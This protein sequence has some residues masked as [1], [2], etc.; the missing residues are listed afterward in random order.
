MAIQITQKITTEAFYDFIEQ[1]ENQNRHFER[2][3]GRIIEKM[4]SG[5]MA[6]IITA[7]I[8][9][10]LVEAIVETGLGIVTSPEGG[11]IVA[12]Q[13]YMPDVAVML[14]SSQSIEERE[15]E[16]GYNTQ[17]PDLAVEVMSSTD[18]HKNLAT[19]V[20]SYNADGT[21]VWV[22]E[23]VDKTITVYAPGKL[24]QYLT[25]DDMLTGGDLILN[26]KLPIKKLFEKR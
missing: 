18:R 5:G 6:P 14:Y 23:P 8:I 9:R 1:A 20:V 3:S 25:E 26:F 7:I 22:V 11:Y 16:R 24:P 13:H 17:A 15:Y 2:I 12:G 4:V 19:K 10:H 21:I